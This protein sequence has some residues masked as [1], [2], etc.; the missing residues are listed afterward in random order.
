[1]STYYRQALVMGMRI[2]DQL[3]L[4]FSFF[5]ALAAVS[6]DIDAVSFPQFLTLRIKLVNFVLYLVFALLWY[7]IFTLCGL[8][9]SRRFASWRSDLTDI[10]NATSLGVLALLIISIFIHISLATPAFL[11]LLWLYT[12]GFT[13]ATRLTLRLLLEHIRRC[14]V[15][16]NN[17]LIVG[18]NPRAVAFAR[19]LENKLEMGYRVVGFV[20]NE[21]AGA[22]RFRDSGYPLVADFAGFTDFLRHQVVDEVV[23]D[24]PLN[25]FYREVIEIVGRCLE[26]GIVVRFISDSLYLVRN[27]KLA[28]SRL[29]KFGDNI[30]ISVQKGAMG[31]WPVI[32]KRVFDIV[33]SFL[34]II[35]LA[36]VFLCI[37][38]LI[39]LT[40]P[41]PVF[42]I[43]ERVGLNKR[44]FR[45]I[46]FRT[47][48]PDAEKQQQELEH[49]NEVSGPAFKIKNDPRTTPIGR[50]LRRT[51]LD[52][53]PQLFNVLQG[54]MS[55]V[56]PRPLPVRDYNGF[57][58]DWHRRRFS[59]R[60]GISCLW[61]ISGRSN[62]PFTKW[63]RLDMEYIDRWSF[64]LDLKIL[65]LTLPAIIKEKG[66]Y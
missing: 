64:W 2:I 51:S 62:L 37:A 32:A 46:K 58:Q 31:G 60:P 54:D 24:L 34:L 13:F 57:N 22:K 21:W 27:L 15:H 29:E 44:R 10:V 28:H 65:A 14:G 52:E 56:G 39:K 7:L 19:T 43:Q 26:Q 53:I 55:L 38:L 45:L 1:M 9:H 35:I 49:F 3:I 63:M 25:T 12:T 41:G 4:L 66:A 11:F 20:D 8:Y 5:L 16:V 47:M 59:V 50:F 6:Q 36:P 33:V 40:S 17:V 30:V 61:Q 42:F 23:I 18:T 48:I